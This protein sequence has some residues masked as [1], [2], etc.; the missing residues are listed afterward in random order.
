MGAAAHDTI[1][2]FVGVFVVALC[3]QA[4]ANA[5]TIFS[6]HLHVVIVVRHRRFY[7]NIFYT[8]PQIRSVRR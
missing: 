2:R 7:I 4:S 1:P 3:Q 6:R 8:A 5:R